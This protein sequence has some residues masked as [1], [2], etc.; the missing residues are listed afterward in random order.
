[1]SV[2]S[3]R[4]FSRSLIRRLPLLALLPLLSLA[5]LAQARVSAKDQAAI[6]TLNQR[7]ATAEKRY[8]DA[9][10]LSA[11][12]DPKG[13]AESDAALE[14]ME[15]VIDACIKQRNCQPHTLLTSYKRLLKQK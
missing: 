2:H 11:N 14:D 6:E 10:V 7:M 1:M 15:D 5:P 9:L 13:Q 12:S 3:Q 4:S 8:A